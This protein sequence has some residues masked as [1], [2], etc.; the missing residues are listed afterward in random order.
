MAQLA[1]GRF[2]PRAFARCQH[3]PRVHPQ[4][5]LALHLPSFLPPRG[6]IMP[7]RAI[8]RPQS[9]C[10]TPKDE[11]LLQGSSGTEQGLRSPSLQLI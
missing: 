7:A 2:S 4:G 1:S 8:H 10:P 11:L 3:P 6:S 9:P 5:N